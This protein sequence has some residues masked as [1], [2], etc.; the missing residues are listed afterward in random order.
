MFS[1]RVKV[2]SDL[3]T[4]GRVFLSHREDWSSLGLSGCNESGVIE[5]SGP[6]SWGAIGY[7]GSKV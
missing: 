5:G 6:V 3:D 1:S 2:R 4:G 7:G